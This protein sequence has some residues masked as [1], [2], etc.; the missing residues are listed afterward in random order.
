MGRDR[1]GLWAEFEYRGVRQRLR[2]IP[3]GRFQMGSP[4][5]EPGRMEREG[6]QHEVT[7]ARGYWLFDTPVTQALW[8]AVM[9]D[10]PARFQS[11]TRPVEQVDF[12]ATKQFIDRINATVP[13]LG[14]VLPSEAQW[15]YASRA[16]TQTALYSGSIDILGVN[17]APALDSIAWYGGNSGVGFELDNGVDVTGFSDRQYPQYKK[18][19]TH[20]VKGK[21]PNPWGLYDM[22]ANVW[23]WTEDGWHE[24][25]A[26]APND[27]AVW[28]GK[29]GG[30]RV[31]RGGSWYD[32]ARNVRC[33]IRYHSHPGSRDGLLGF[34]CARVQA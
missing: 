25:Y 32:Y 22:L 3:P 30:L 7:L 26:G 33:A 24:N 8:M 14:L 10:N 34:R 4:G 6:P 2:W 31:V 13:A 19:G 1:H 20:P 12:V 15:E 29:A 21:A 28:E 23:E 11:P 5:D 27:G 18:A 17:N 9:G 16:G